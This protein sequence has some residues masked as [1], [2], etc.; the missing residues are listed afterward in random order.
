M[1]IEI[2]INEN[3][4]KNN[5]YINDLIENNKN[6][7]ITISVKFFKC[8]Y[9]SFIESDETKTNTYNNYKLQKIGKYDIIKCIY[10]NVKDE[11]S[12][13]LLLQIKP[14]LALLIHQNIEKK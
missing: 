8:I 14:S 5:K 4:I 7:K 2:D 11:N 13:Y 1:E 12:R 10:D 3:D 9:N 6:D